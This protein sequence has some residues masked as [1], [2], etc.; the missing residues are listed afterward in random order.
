MPFLKRLLAREHYR[1]HT[2]YPG[3]PSTT[4]AVQ[5]ELYYGLRA[6]VP[7]FNF[8]D[9]I[10]KEHGVMAYPEWAKDFEASYA[11]QAE[12]LLKGGSCWSNI[13][14]GGASQE[15]SH[16]CGASLGVGDMWRS[17]AMLKFF[18][19]IG[20]HFVAVIRIV[21]LMLLELA[22]AAW[23]VVVGVTRGESIWHE[24]HMALS[25]ALVAIGLREIV[26]VG[27]SLDLTRGLPVIHVN[28]LGYDEA[29]HRRGPGSRFA[30]WSLRGIDRY[31]KALYYTAQGSTRRGLRRVDFLRPWPATHGILCAEISRW[32]RAHRPRMPRRCAKTR[33]RMA[34]AFAAPTGGTVVAPT[35]TGQ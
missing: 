32:H 25:R 23:D 3:L 10:K 31:I 6:A 11:A 16:F 14:T 2:F 26:K 22:L 13:Y 1:L 8:F 33:P 15:E 24:V 30:H 5:A 29:A 9:R 12:G 17:G 18:V 7:A 34:S 28:F 21:L 4:P 20:L 27:A 19:F 35:Q